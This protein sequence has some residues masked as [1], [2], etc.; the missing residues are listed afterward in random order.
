MTS[1]TVMD[2][3]IINANNDLQLLL[4]VY[5]RLL[6]SVSELDKGLS[7]AIGGRWSPVC[8]PSSVVI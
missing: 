7:V 5:F 2:R 4:S 1:G 6:K 3:V 8:L